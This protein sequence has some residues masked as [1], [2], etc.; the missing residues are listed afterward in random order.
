MIEGFITM[1]DLGPHLEA[2]NLVL[3]QFNVLSFV[4]NS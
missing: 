3:V 2:Y 4:R 1:F